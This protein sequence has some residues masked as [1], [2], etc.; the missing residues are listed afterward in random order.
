MILLSQPP[1][2]WDYSTCSTATLKSLSHSCLWPS[3]SLSSACIT[4]NTDPPQFPFITEMGRRRM[5]WQEACVR[6]LSSTFS[7]GEHKSKENSYISETNVN[8]MNGWKVRQT[9]HPFCHWTYSL[10]TQGSWCLCVWFV[11]FFFFLEDLC[12]TK[13][14]Y[15][16]DLTSKSLDKDLLFSWELQKLAVL[17][18]N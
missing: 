4:P 13:V 17:K 16:S 11:R 5:C 2:C 14:H 10:P 3:M 15:L 8:E 12:L 18:K 6:H 1:W 9:I 7:Q